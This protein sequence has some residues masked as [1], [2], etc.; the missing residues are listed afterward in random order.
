MRYIGNTVR[1][2]TT[3]VITGRDG[4]KCVLVTRG[5]GNA[6]IIGN[7]VMMDGLGNAIRVEA[8]KGCIVADNTIWSARAPGALDSSGIDIRTAGIDN[9]SVQVTGNRIYTVPGGRTW[10]YGIRVQATNSTAIESANVSNNSVTNAGTG[11]YFTTASG[12]TID[13][14]PIVIG[15]I[16]KTVSNPLVPN[17]QAP[18][19]QIAGSG[20]VDAGAFGVFY[21]MGSPEGVLY[22]EKGST[23]Q[24]YDG[25]SGGV[26][27]AYV[28][29]TAATL[30][31]GWVSAVATNSIW[32]ESFGRRK[33]LMYIPS[34]SANT[35]SSVGLPAQNATT[36]TAISPT[37][38]NAA[39]RNARVRYDAAAAAVAYFYPNALH[40][41]I[42][43]GTSGGFRLTQSYLT[44]DTAADGRMFVGLRNVAAVPTSADPATLTNCVG[45]AQIDGSVN[46]HI[47]YGGSAAQT[48]IDLGANFPAATAATDW[49]CVTFEALPTVA[50]TVYYTVRRIG[51]AH[52]A[53]GTLTGTAGVALPASTAG[54]TFYYWRTSATVA[55]SIHVGSTENIT[56]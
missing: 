55:T 47:V 30:N 53:T 7:S 1:S 44:N 19:M 27:L 4:I 12:G 38:T 22:A 40:C 42:S 3:D 18:W 54:L 41:T 34:L 33:R 52:V 9:E 17:A 37:F 11:V 28:K 16:F 14:P 15:N 51:T 6:S 23:A 43:D 31:T 25:G 2:R 48:P 56:G 39:V 36:A 8:A 24:V 26:E 50:D 13:S 20:G 5:P 46:L 35:F 10:L 29:T 21:G 32:N 45:L 49:Y